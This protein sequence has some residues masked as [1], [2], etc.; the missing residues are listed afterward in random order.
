MENRNRSEK[1]LLVVSSVTYAM[2]GRELLFRKGIRSYIERLPRTK[3]TGCG[4]G[5]YVPDGPDA[6]ERIL[7]EAGFRV[8]QRRERGGAA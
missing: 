8:Y 7:K 4:Y 2:R 3:E 1:T 5:L 6:A